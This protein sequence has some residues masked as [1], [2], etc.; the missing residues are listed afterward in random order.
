M[1]CRGIRSQLLLPEYGSKA[2]L[3]ER[4]LLAIHEGGVG[5]GFG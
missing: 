5:F 2:E 1:R 4:L 3:Q